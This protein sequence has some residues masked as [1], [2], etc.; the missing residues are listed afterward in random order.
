MLG[1]GNED[2]AMDLLNVT[3]D[4]SPFTQRL[5]HLVDELLGKDVE[6]SVKEIDDKY[7]Y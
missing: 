3:N 2:A 5:A 7:P 1:I 6:A 4:K